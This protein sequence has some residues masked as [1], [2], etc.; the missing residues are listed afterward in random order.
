MAITP[1]RGRKPGIFGRRS[2]S[3]LRPR[4]GVIET[5]SGDGMT[6]NQQRSD[7]IRR[8]TF[9]RVSSTAI[10]TISRGAK[11]DLMA[12]RDLVELA[13]R[14][15]RCAVHPPAG[16]PTV[17]P[18]HRLP[19]DLAEFYQLCGGV[20]LYRG[21]DYEISITSLAQLLESNVVIVGEQFF[22]DIS[23]SWYTIATTPDREYV[24]IDLAAERN[25][26]CYDSFH[27]VHGIAGSSPIIAT[28]FSELFENLLNSRGGYWYW[29][30]SDFASPGDAYD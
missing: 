2:R 8:R 6:T 24:S 17:R 19:D 21:A 9:G 28:S 7:Y 30:K 11:G 5:P 20:D 22:G 23:A 18:E 10:S 25:G 27:E 26:Q 16:V 15:D 29:L 3:K 14:S 4:L 12:V 13:S 1:S